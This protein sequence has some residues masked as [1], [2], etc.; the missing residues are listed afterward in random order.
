MN[1][2]WIELQHEPFEVDVQSV[3]DH[4]GQDFYKR[5]LNFWEQRP[6]TVF[7]MTN[8]PDAISAS[9]LAFTKRVV[10][11]YVKERNVPTGLIADV[12]CGIGRVSVNV[13]SDFYHRIDLVD[14][15]ERF[16]LKAEEELTG[17]GIEVNKYIVGAQDWTPEKNYDAYWCQWVAT[18]LIDDDLVSFLQRCKQHLNK[19]GVVFV[20]D[21]IVL[22]EDQNEAVYSP[23]EHYTTRTITHFR[24][25]FQQAG[26]QVDL[27][28]LQPDWPETERQ[29]ICLFVLK[30]S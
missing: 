30:P 5:A 25:L 16:V 17:I 26:F 14:P 9:D 23:G 7:G 12:A 10:S 11:L 6:A 3:F 19:N 4:Y 20:K 15:I 28:H 27:A 29:A 22:S 24:D 1:P 8:L 2:E 13:L 18:Y 21:N